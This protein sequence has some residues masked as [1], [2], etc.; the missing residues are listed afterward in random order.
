MIRRQ[1]AWRL[2]SCAAILVFAGGCADD[3]GTDGAAPSAEPEL[4]SEGEALFQETC[5]ACHGADLDGTDSGPSFLSSIYA[6][7][8]H[9]D[10]SFYAAVENG[11]QP[12]HWDFGPMPPQPDISPEDVEAIVAY[13][14]AQQVEAG[15]IQEQ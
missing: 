7:D 6:P 3:G 10:E 2:L 14:R 5:A 8:H 12:H 11:V 9:S 15:V 13:V 1:L 4:V